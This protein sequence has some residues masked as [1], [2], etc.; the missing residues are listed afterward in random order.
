M[1]REVRAGP[2]VQHEADR[3]RHV[4]G[5]GGGE[6]RDGDGSRGRLLEHLRGAALL[7]AE[8]QSEPIRV[9]PEGLE[10]NLAVGVE[11]HHRD[12]LPADEVDG[13]LA[14]G[15][16]HRQGED[17]AA[18]GTDQSSV[19]DA[20]EIAVDEHDPGGAQG[21][22]R[23]RDGADVAD[24]LH[25]VEHDD[26]PA[27]LGEVAE[28]RRPRHPRDT[29]GLGLAFALEDLVD[30]RGGEQPD[31]DVPLPAQV[32]QFLGRRLGL[33]PVDLGELHT[34]LEAL[35]EGLGVFDQGRL[36]VGPGTLGDIEDP[37]D[38]RIG[39]VFDDF[40]VVHGPVSRVRRLGR[41]AKVQSAMVPREAPPTRPLPPRTPSTQPVSGGRGSPKP[42]RSRTRRPTPSTARSASRTSRWE[43]VK[44]S[45]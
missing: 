2:L 4:E 15:Q 12:A 40:Q 31:R 14:S 36:D 32:H 24:D 3:H 41:R 26:V 8:Q 10:R 25:S 30:D 23:T 45:R 38:R 22:R 16:D 34:G 27:A 37:S 44:G 5:L 28:P 21:Q 19:G 7:T 17:V 18:A 13:L 9:V 1:G 43:G 20:G 33:D 6:H 29:E 42:A 35:D 39:G 11:H